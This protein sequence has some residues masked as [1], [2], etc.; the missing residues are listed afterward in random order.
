MPSEDFIRYV[1]LLSKTPGANRDP[2]V[3]SS[4]VSHLRNLDRQGKLVLCGPFLDV[5]GGMIVIKAASLDEAKR[6]AAEDPFVTEGHRSFEVR[7]WQLSCEE[8]NHLGG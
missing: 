1:I 4:H 6:L 2:G 7:T 8:N 3:I 5:D